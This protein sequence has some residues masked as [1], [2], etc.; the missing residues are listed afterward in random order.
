[1]III[2]VIYL[3]F[4]KIIEYTLIFFWKY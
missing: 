2:Y 3:I 4:F 1:M